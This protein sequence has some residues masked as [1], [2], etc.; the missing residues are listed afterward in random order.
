MGIVVLV[1][2]IVIIH[3]RSLFQHRPHDTFA[4]KGPDRG[5]LVLGCNILS[6]SS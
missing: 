2:G 6:Q 4:M 5:A 3:G 1:P